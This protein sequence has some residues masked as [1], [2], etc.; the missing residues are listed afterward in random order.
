MKQQFI[1]VQEL[2]T[3]PHA[4]NSWRIRDGWVEVHQTVDG[5]PG[6]SLFPPSFPFPI[7]IVTVEE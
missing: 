7:V 6:I 4:I 3:E 2:H 5:N 1:Q